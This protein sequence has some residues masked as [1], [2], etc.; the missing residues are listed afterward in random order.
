MKVG[1]W[2]GPDNEVLYDSLTDEVIFREVNKESPTVVCIN[3]LDLMRARLRAR[4]P[5]TT[6]AVESYEVSQ[7]RVR[8][9][10]GK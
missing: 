6:P 1:I 7:T 3:Y 8:R 2:I 10:P 9:K 5:A 4:A